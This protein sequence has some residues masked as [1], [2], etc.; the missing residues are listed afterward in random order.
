MYTM[1]RTAV[2]G[3]ACLLALAAWPAPSGR[4]QPLETTGRPQVL[5]RV[6]VVHVRS[7]T[8]DGRTSPLSGPLSLV[9]GPLR[10]Y[11]EPATRA[12][13]EAAFPFVEFALETLKRTADVQTV[14][15]QSAIVEQGSRQSMRFDPDVWCGWQS[16]APCFPV[17]HPTWLSPPLQLDFEPTR[18]EAGAIALRV[19]AAVATDE[20]WRDHRPA[21]ALVAVDDGEPII[22][23][24]ASTAADASGPPERDAGALPAPYGVLLVVSAYDVTSQAQISA[25]L[26]LEEARDA[27][28]RQRVRMHQEAVA[29][30][31]DL[32][33]RRGLLHDIHLTL[34]GAA[35][36]GTELPR[37]P[38]IPLYCSTGLPWE[39][40]ALGLR[41]PTVTQRDGATIAVAA[42]P[43]SDDTPCRALRPDGSHRVTTF[44][45]ARKEQAR[46]PGR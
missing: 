19:A 5:V 10:R 24:L 27:A 1:T 11:L 22:L 9:E 23:W 32:S 14:A 7:A 6:M 43:P 45:A 30:V 12:S 42:A 46:S 8:D 26:E 44:G 37:T 41:G 21:P 39:G 20:A 17:E 18:V 2:F 35:S 38:R 29:G 31:L 28:R 33:G 25:F 4:A 3:A 16:L 15:W 13:T 36:S 40:L 34:T